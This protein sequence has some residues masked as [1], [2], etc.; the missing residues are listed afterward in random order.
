MLRRKLK[1]T[2]A[3]A[4]FSYVLRPAVAVSDGNTIR[5]VMQT[6]TNMWKLMTVW[7]AL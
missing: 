2:T 4:P 7:T 5:A 6:S 1:N 3:A